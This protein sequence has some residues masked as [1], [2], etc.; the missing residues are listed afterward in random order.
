MHMVVF[1]CLAFRFG[2]F[3]SLSYLSYSKT[4]TQQV[5][6]T[7]ELTFSI[8]R[9]VYQSGQFILHILAVLSRVYQSKGW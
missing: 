2:L 9:Y 5:S 7:L 3:C 4:E 6:A 8:L 1:G